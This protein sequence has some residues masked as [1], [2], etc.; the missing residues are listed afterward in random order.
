MKQVIFKCFAALGIIA[1]SMA[2]Y[3]CSSDGEVVEPIV[4]NERKPIELDG[5]TRAAAASLKDFYVGFT[6][7]ATEYVDGDD[8]FK[9]K[10]VVVSPLSAYMVLAVMANGVDED[11]SEEIVRYLG[12]DNLSALNSLASTL[13]DKLPVADNQT[14]MKLVNS[15]WVNKLK[16]NPGYAGLIGKDYLAEINY[17]DFSGNTKKVLKKINKWC[18]EKTNG[19]IPKM[20]DDLD[21]SCMAIILN[22]MYFKGLWEEETFLTENTGKDVF[23]GSKG[24]SEVDMMYAYSKHRLYAA[25]DNFDLFFLPFGNGSFSLMVLLPNENLSLEE[26]NSMLTPEMLTRL[27]DGLVDCNLS[28][29]LPRFKV[30]NKLPLNDIFGLGNL[31]VDRPLMFN[32]FEPKQSGLVNFKQAAV[33]EIDEAGVKAAAVT[34]GEIDT[35][36][37]VAG[38]SYS[39]KVDR[40]FY[41]FLQENSTGA[42]LLSGRIAD[43]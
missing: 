17:E 37:P 25:D 41:F 10:N 9:S 35:A 4:P 21:P 34:G 8:M 6:A 22:A 16:L 23:H 39:V 33:L 2:F 27:R 40:P 11:M 5:E 7:D 13:L 38:G 43:L 36:A 20:Y 24:D 26:A 28:V 15:V 31:N 42:C 18:S 12:T 30:E 3:S 14:D 1:G 32:M 29:Y 19:L